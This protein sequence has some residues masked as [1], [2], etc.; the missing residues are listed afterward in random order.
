MDAPPG[1][2]PHSPKKTFALDGLL[3]V[4]ALI[5][6]LV[7]LFLFVQGIEP[8]GSSAEL[9]WIIFVS[10]PLITALLFALRH[11]FALAEY[12]A[13]ANVSRPL[14]KAIIW[15]GLAYVIAMSA[16]L[17]C[18]SIINS[19]WS[20]NEPGL[21]AVFCGGGTVF[22]YFGAWLASLIFIARIVALANGFNMTE[23]L[24]ALWDR[25]RHRRQ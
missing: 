21:K 24:A 1:S 12:W 10:V 18:P 9:F 6:S 25:L 23:Q 14:K 8:N 16:S 17:A 2:R 3:L 13:L 4:G 19:I 5:A 11:R 15:M 22:G 7:C 20:E